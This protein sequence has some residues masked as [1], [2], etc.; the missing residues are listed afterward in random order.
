VDRPHIAIIGAGMAGVAAAVRLLQAGLEDFTIYEKSS[1]PGGVWWDNRYPGAAVDTPSH[2]YSFS[3]L[4]HDWPRRFA[5][6]AE[7]LQYIARVV[8]EYDLERHMRYGAEVTEAVWED[9]E[10]GYRLYLANGDSEVVSYLISAVGL[11]NV[12][13]YPAWPG[14][15]EFSGPMFHTS[16]WE[17]EHE[18]TGRRIAVV[19]TGSTAI[20]VVPAVAK[21]AAR[22]TVFQREPGWIDPKPVHEYSRAER[23]SL[24]RPW[25]YRLERLRCYL[26]YERKNFR[27]ALSVEGTRINRLGQE[28]A[29]N[30]V[31]SLLAGRPDLQ[32]MVTPSYPYMGKRPIHDSDFYPALLRDNV[33]L[34]PHAVVRVTQAG[35]IDAEGELHEADV[36][37]LSTGFQPSNFLAQLKVTGREGVELHEFWKDEPAAFLGT[38]V[39]GFPNFFMLYGPN[40]NM[41]AIAFILEQ[42]ADIAVRSI[43]RALRR[44]A[45]ATEVTT[46]AYERYNRWLQRRLART[47]FPGARNYYKATTGKVVTQWP[48]GALVFWLMNKLWVDRATTLTRRSGPE[49]TS[50]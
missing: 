6:Q 32:A 39:P 45:T 22:V 24:V 1:G 41:Y 42:G 5:T 34:V 9:A 33:T 23:R 16:R 18:L 47:V 12:P 10:Q 8:D 48:D 50:R 28:R 37:V 49:G 26:R 4:R 17:N 44:G 35:L 25:R 46:R 36:V 7:L 13:R 30:N 29:L 27:G 14:M 31:R 3:F 19:G 20:Q 38:T 11:L 21:I 43:T 15:D 2:M 40:T